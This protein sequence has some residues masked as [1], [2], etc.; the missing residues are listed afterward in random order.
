MLQTIQIKS[1]S[2]HMAQKKI[3]TQIFTATIRKNQ[4]TPLEKLNWDSNL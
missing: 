3:L 1:C 2:F 4:V